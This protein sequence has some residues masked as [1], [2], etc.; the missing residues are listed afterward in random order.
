MKC[1]FTLF[2][3]VASVFTISAVGTASA[4]KQDTI[5]PIMRLPV[6]E[7][8]AG[9]HLSQAQL[10]SL[11][12]FVDFHIRNGLRG[13]SKAYGSEQTRVI[14]T[15]KDFTYFV[16]QVGDAYIIRFFKIK[17]AELEQVNLEQL[18]GAQIRK[19]FTEEIIPESDKL[20]VRRKTKWD[21]ITYF[22]SQ[23][24]YQYLPETK[25]LEV[26]YLWKKTGEFGRKIIHKEYRALYDPALKQFSDIR[27]NSMIKK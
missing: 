15:D 16:R 10:F 17:T 19:R 5:V 7:I 12:Q 6:A 11:P 1:R 26:V 3:A 14:H 20:L 13:A 25:Q 23:F 22:D 9:Q 27:V 8:E 18:D 21:I 24:S 2:V 4:G